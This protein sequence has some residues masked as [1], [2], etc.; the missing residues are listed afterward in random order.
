MKFSN[1]YWFYFAV[2]MTLV[3][4]GVVVGMGSKIEAAETRERAAWEVAFAVQKSKGCLCV[5]G[6]KP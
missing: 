4:M 6:A 1:D 5:E 3:A 2:V